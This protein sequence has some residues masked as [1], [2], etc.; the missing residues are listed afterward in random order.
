MINSA[1]S[2]GNA[3][4][5]AKL[6]IIRDAKIAGE[7]LTGYATGGVNDETG[8]YKLHGNENAVETIFNAADGKKLFDFINKTP[9]IAAT[10]ARNL[11]QSIPSSYF[12]QTSSDL[13]NNRESSLSIAQMD[14]YTTDA[15]DFMK[16]MKN[17]VTITG[18]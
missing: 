14:V 6:K 18:K 10:F 12:N 13:T 15:N 17:L 2:S 5:A 7:K 4:E 9:D 1:E 11:T 3:S 16:Q 8:I